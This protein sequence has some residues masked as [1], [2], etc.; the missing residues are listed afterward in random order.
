VRPL[1]AK[2]HLNENMEENRRYKARCAVFGSK[3][4]PKIDW[5]I[6]G[7]KI[8]TAHPT[9]LYLETIYLI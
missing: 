7:K 9:V 1:R 2:I 8:D 6:N 5:Y 4:P 3:P